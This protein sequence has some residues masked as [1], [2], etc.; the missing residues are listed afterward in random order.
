M[1]YSTD[2]KTEWISQEIAALQEQG[3]FNTIRTIETPMDAHIV[4]NGKPVI[5]ILC[6][7]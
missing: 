4:V 6:S 2:S 5:N 1:E 3:L 7:Y